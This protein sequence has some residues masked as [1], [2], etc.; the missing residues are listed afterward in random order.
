MN[1]PPARLTK[2]KKERKIKEIINMRKE[3]K[4][5]TIDFRHL[6]NYGILMI[7]REYNFMPT[8]SET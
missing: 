6:N 3:S 2:K 4:V 1:K 5:I 7:I 8:K